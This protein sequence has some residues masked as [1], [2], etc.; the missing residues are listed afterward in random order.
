MHLSLFRI[1]CSLALSLASLGLAAPR[2]QAQ[3]AGTKLWSFSTGGKVASGPAIGLDGTVYVGSEDRK[4]YALTS[5]GAK[6]WEF[7]TAD[8]ITACPAIGTDGTIFVGSTDG[9]LYAVNP[10]GKQLW[11]FATGSPISEPPALAVDGTVYLVSADGNLYALHP[12]GSEKW[13]FKTG[14]VQ[15]FGEDY[16]VPAP[17]VGLDGTVYV[18]STV[19]LGNYSPRLNAL[20]PHG[21]VKWSFIRPLERVG[22]DAVLDLGGTVYFYS[23]LSG[24]LFALDASG[25]QKWAAFV[26]QV[27]IGEAGRLFGRSSGWPIAL[28]ADGTK[29][30]HSFS[31]SGSPTTPPAIAT[32]GTFYF[33]TDEGIL[34]ALKSDGAVLWGF[35]TG[36]SINSAPALAANGTVYFGADDGN[37]YAVKGAAG[38]VASAWPMYR[39]NAQRTGAH[40]NTVLTDT[41]LAL[42][43]YPGLLINGSVGVSYRIEHRPDLASPW[44]FLATVTLDKTPYP[45][46]DLN[47]DPTQKR[48]YRA[49]KLP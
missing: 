18:S 25:K 16:S 26:G 9:T 38:P 13:R 17:T 32:D 15:D 34:Y 31:G 12:N 33:G 28:R 19:F 27:S 43:L 24:N 6:R 8:A 10:A 48:F 7:P 41:E 4:L 3:Q 44:E 49:I 21:A 45:F 20:D 5:G 35:E 22:S 46:F 36:S 14:T 30:W 37:L 47:A 29:L 2:L 1:F 11:K 39:G 23:D 40:W 42:R